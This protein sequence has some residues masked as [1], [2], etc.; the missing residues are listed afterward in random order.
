MVKVKEAGSYDRALEDLLFE[1]PDLDKGIEKRVIWFKKN[2]KDT[3]LENH[4]LTK[5]MEGKWAFSVTDDIRIIYK[6]TNQTT[7]RFLA[8]G[9][10]IKV[11]RKARAKKQS[12][13]R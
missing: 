10:H 6:W 13:K 7:A 8:I 2:P 9:P 12:P 1:N 4:P 11:Y 5:P 3:R